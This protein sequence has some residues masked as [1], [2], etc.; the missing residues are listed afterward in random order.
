MLSRWGALAHGIG[1]DAALLDVPAGSRLAVSTDTSVENVHFR[2]AW[3]SAEEIAYRAGGRGAERPRRDGRDAARRWSSRSRS[4]AEWRAQVARL[5]DGFAAGVAEHGA[6]I[7]GGDLSAGSEL[8]IGVTVLGSVARPLTRAGARAGDALLVT[9]RSA[10]RC[11]RCA[12]SRRGRSRRRRTA[13]GS[14]I[15]FRGCA[16]RAG[17]RST[18]RPP[19]STAP[20]ASPPTRRTSRRR[21]ACASRWTSTACRWS[22]ARSREDAARSGEEYELIVTAPGDARHGVRSSA[23]S[24]SRSPRSAAWRPPD[25]EGAGVTTTARRP[26]GAVSARTQPFFRMIRTAFTHARVRPLHAHLRADG[27]RRRAAGPKDGLGSI[28]DWAMRIW[29]TTAA[30]A[31]GD[32]GRRARPREPGGRAAHHREQ[33]HV[34]ARHSRARVGAEEPQVRREE[35]AREGPVL[36]EA[37]PRRSAPCTSS[38]RTGRA[39]SIRTG[40]PPRRFGTARA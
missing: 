30:W 25:A 26:T 38:G 20:T 24:A 8:S 34:A 7:V 12:R 16:R 29:G 1:D 5:A 4:R 40:R 32:E 27:S 33:S 22:R 10:A 14:R 19:R 6:P 9:G 36:R 18:A 17:S 11:S 31:S 23:S 28:F 15:R 2:R 39:A 35:R 13:S 37:P 3:I 21:A